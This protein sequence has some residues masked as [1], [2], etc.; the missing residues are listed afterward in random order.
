MEVR[1]IAPLL[2]TQL[3]VTPN[4]GNAVTHDCQCFLDFERKYK[5]STTKISFSK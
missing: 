2:C 1:L 3:G 4:T 5:T